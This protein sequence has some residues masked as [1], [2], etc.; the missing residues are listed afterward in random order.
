VRFTQLVNIGTSA[1]HTRPPLR[2]RRMVRPPKWNW[3]LIPCWE[4]SPD[5]CK[6]WNRSKELAWKRADS[7]HAPRK[8]PW[9]RGRFG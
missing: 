3:A 2:M 4:A 7:A 8:V 5:G 9:S 6:L 1:A